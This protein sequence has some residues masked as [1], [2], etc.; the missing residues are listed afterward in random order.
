[1]N[2]ILTIMDENGNAREVE[3]VATLEIEGVT[4]IVLREAEDDA[5]MAFELA[6]DGE[7]LEPVENEALLDVI[8]E[9]LD[10]VL[11]AESE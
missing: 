8:S 3:E 9:A 6:S 1:M 2:E 5:L 4:Y 11:G 7:S 10:A